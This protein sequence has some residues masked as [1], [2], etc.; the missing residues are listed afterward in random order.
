[1][2]REDRGARAGRDAREE[3]GESDR[4]DA[5]RKRIS[6]WMGG[7]FVLCFLALMWPIAGLAN[8]VEP[9]VLGMPFFFFWYV[10]WAFLVFVGCLVTYRWEYGD[11]GEE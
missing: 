4:R 7:Y 10:L 9:Y 1:M 8:R 2:D 5:R 6:L 3:A 11:G